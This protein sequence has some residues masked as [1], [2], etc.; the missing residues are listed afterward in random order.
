MA[1]PLYA[2]LR[3]FV[4]ISGLPPAADDL[5]KRMFSIVADFVGPCA[6]THP[7]YHD[8]H[9]GHSP[10]HHESGTILRTPKLSVLGFVSL[11]LGISS[12]LMLFGSLAFMLGFML[13]PLIVPASIAVCVGALLSTIKE[14][15]HSMPASSASLQGEKILQTKALF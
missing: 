13:M 3:S 1:A 6:I 12:T 7:S 2:N 4:C 14:G 8:R 5:L 15:R 11:L 10:H 9:L